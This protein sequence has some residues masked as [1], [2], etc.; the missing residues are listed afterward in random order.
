MVSQ[1]LESH[2]MYFKTCIAIQYAIHVKLNENSMTWC[3]L[4]LFHCRVC[5]LNCWIYIFQDLRASGSPIDR[6][7]GCNP[8]KWKLVGSHW[9]QVTLRTTSTV[10]SHVLHWLWQ[11]PW[12]HARFS[13]KTWSSAQRGGFYRIPWFVLPLFLNSGGELP[14]LNDGNCCIYLLIL[15]S[16]FLCLVNTNTGFE[17]ALDASGRRC[18]TALNPGHQIIPGP[19]PEAPKKIECLPNKLW[20]FAP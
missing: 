3:L 13:L 19:Q 7:I 17:G 18:F 2:S 12:F 20:N 6:S 15:I 9:G 4:I 14:T 1:C 11:D 5:W 16:N 8:Y 10:W